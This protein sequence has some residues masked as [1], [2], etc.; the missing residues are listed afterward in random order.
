MISTII[1]PRDHTSKLQHLHISLSFDELL[2]FCPLFLFVDIINAMS[3]GERYSGVVPV[4][5]IS[6]ANLNDDPKSTSFTVSIRV[7]SSLS[8]TSRLSGLI[9]ECTSSTF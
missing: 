3:S 8:S 9:S 5:C 4:I 6:L 7:L 2:D 1:T